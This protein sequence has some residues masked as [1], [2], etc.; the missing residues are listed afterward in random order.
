VQRFVEKHFT[1]TEI[2]D[3][4][5][6]A[7]RNRRLYPE[8]VLTTEYYTEAFRNRYFEKYISCVFLSQDRVCRIYDARPLVCRN[9]MAFTDPAQCRIG[10][11]VAISDAE[12]IADVHTAVP[13]LSLLVYKDLTYRQHLSRWFMEEFPL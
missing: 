3:V 10:E 2:E 12:Y 6:T 8:P 4:I 7:K 13:C 1:A 9:Y 11:D 5:E